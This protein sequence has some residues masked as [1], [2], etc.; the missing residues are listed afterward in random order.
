MAIL[1]N[2]RWATYEEKII[3]SSHTQKERK[4]L[5][6]PQSDKKRLRYG[7]LMKIR[8]KTRLQTY[9]GTLSLTI[10]PLSV[11]Q[12]LYTICQLFR[13]I[14]EFLRRQPYGI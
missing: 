1:R 9:K 10:L 4:F 8:L 7:N 12:I 2:R 3:R 11:R 13:R 6:S 14:T 5:I